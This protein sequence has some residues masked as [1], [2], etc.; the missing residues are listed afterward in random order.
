VVAFPAC[1]AALCRKYLFSLALEKTYSGLHGYM[2]GQMTH[3]ETDETI[4][5]DAENWGW[6]ELLTGIT[7]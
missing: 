2:A 7:M 5:A 4:P 3:Y 1:R 6:E